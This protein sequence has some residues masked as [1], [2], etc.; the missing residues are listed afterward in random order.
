MAP[1]PSLGCLL[2][3]GSHLFLHL[4]LR[5]WCSLS[6]HMEEAPRPEPEPPRALTCPQCLQDFKSFLAPGSPAS[7]TQNCAPTAVKPLSAPAVYRYR[8]LHQP[9]WSRL[10]P[11]HCALAFAEARSSPH[12]SRTTRLEGLFWV[13]GE[14]QGS[15]ESCFLLRE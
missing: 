5:T 2:L 14:S 11:A 12:T 7:P 10:T 6:V 8:F 3:T 9:G 13:L 4:C 1:P 15:T